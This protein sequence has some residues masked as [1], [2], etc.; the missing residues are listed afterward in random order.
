[1]N[2]NIG[3][4]ENREHP[5]STYF[6]FPQNLSSRQNQYTKIRFK[7]YGMVSGER[8]FPQTPSLEDGMKCD[9]KCAW[10]DRFV[11]NIE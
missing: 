8:S 2:L 3:E 4:N 10:R 5:F 7:I 9:I 11:C 1:M 6:V